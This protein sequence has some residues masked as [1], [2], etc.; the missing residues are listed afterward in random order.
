MDNKK[1]RTLLLLLFFLIFTF[2]AASNSMQKWKGKVRN[3]NGV[4]IIENHGLGI[5][6]KN[7]KDR[8]KFIETLS[9]GAEADKAP[10]YLVFGRNIMVDVDPDQNIFVL[11]IQNYRLL[12]F[13]QKGQF[14]WK[15]SRQG[16]GPGEIEAPSSIKATE[17]GGIAVVDQGG[18]LHYFDKNGNFLKTVKMAKLIK[19]VISFDNGNIFAMLWIQGQPGIAAAMFSEGGELIKPFPVEYYYGPKLSPRIGYDLGAK[20]NLGGDHL[21]LSLPDKYEIQIYSLEGQLQKK[22]TRDIKIRPP[23]LEEG[24]RFVVRDVS[25]PCHLMSNGFLINKL[26]IKE[27]ATEEKEKKYLDFFNDKFEFLGSFELQENVYLAM[28]DKYDNFYFVQTDPF[29][30]IIRCALKIS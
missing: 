13:N 8:I 18:K 23:L 6:G 10:E 21:F 3:V 26:S 27:S 22:V 25:G 12:K 1:E 11:D 15:A 2:Y 17:N 14:L 7:I 16:Q 24:Y 5:Y 4:T 9:L 30:K 28:I 29:L 19:S 20:F